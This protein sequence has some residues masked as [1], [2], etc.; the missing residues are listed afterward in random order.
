MPLNGLSLNNITGRFAL[1]LINE[2]QTLVP[3]L[4]LKYYKQLVISDQELV[5]L[6]HLL[7]LRN[8]EKNYY[9]S[10]EKLSQLMTAGTEEIKERLAQLMEKRFLA[11]DKQYFQET[12]E[13]K[14][15][16]SLAPLIE[17]L[18]V[19]WAMEKQ[20]NWLEVQKHLK[21]GTTLLSKVCKD[22]ERQFGRL[23]SPVE[24]DQIRLWAVEM[25]I[26][27]ELINEALRRALLMGVQNLKYIDKI[28]L[29]WQ[30][31]NLRSLE[32]IAR[33]E[34]DQKH[35]VPKVPNNKKNVDKAEPDDKFRLLN[36]G[37]MGGSA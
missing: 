31:H 27:R 4:L 3:N 11:I 22:F 2:S 37:N 28:L 23:L 25:G 24:V 33:F 13:V 15:S 34:A 18:S 19:L 17:E 8:S 35:R 26:S 10:P 1:D 20:Q 5:L 7:Y 30:K 36:W 21:T 6:I 14:D 9:P 29:E 12:D 32:E 16:Y